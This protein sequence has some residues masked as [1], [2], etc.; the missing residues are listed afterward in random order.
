MCDVVSSGVICITIDGMWAL[1]IFAIVEM[2]VGRNNKVL[3]TQILGPPPCCNSEDLLGFLHLLSKTPV[4]V[5][6]TT[7]TNVSLQR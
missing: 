1:F 3:M 5:D 4:L 2:G 7:P 6:Y